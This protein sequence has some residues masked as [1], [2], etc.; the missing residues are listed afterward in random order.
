MKLASRTT[1]FVRKL[2]GLPLR[3]VKE[4]TYAYGK[5]DKKDFPPLLKPSKNLAIIQWVRWYWRAFALPFLPEGIVQP[6]RIPF[7]VSI[8]V[9]LFGV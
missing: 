7:N 1:C 4:F 9:H 3:I 5:S 6:S 8:E 2:R